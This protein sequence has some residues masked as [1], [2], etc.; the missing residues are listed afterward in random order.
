MALSLT[1]TRGYTAVDGTPIDT[2]DYNA[3]FLPS[4]TLSGSV[5]GDELGSVPISK[6]T[7]GALFYAA[8]SGSGGAYAVTLNPAL[9]AYAAGVQLWFLANHTN[10]GAATLNVNGLGAKAIVRPNGQALTGAEIESGQLCHVQYDGTSFQL[11]STT[12]MPAALY[13]VDSGAADA[14]VAAFG[15]IAPTELAD[16]LG[17]PLTFKAANANTGASTLAVNGLAATAIRK[18]GTTALSANDI[19]AGQLV[20]VQYDGTYFQIMGFVSAPSLPSIVA[21]GSATYPYSLTWDAQGRLTAAPTGH[22]A[23]TAVAVPSAGATASFTH[24]LGRTPAYV[25]AVLV[26]GTTENNHSVGDEVAVQEV[27]WNDPSNEPHESFH[28]TANTTTVVVTRTSQ[29][30]GTHYMMNKTTGDAAATV[31]FANWQVKVYAN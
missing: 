22:Y 14:Y 19:L 31:N 21:A 23:A 2:A 15:Q 27:H 20:T 10:G 4:V 7:P 24:S 8:A 28:V 29:A 17:I 9:T 13:A 1:V 25:R 5:T 30:G 12:A 3:G 6:I 26:C 16:L 11:L 18:G